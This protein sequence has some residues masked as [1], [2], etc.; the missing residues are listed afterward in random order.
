MSDPPTDLASAVVLDPGNERGYHRSPEMQQSFE[1][2]AARLLASDGWPDPHQAGARRLVA[3]LAL[4]GGGVKGIGLVGAVLVLDEAGYRFRAVAGSSAGAIAASLVTGLTKAGKPMTELRRYLQQLDFREFMP[5]GKVRAFFEHHGGKAGEF[6]TDAAV[7]A[8]QPGLYTGDYLKKWLTP[9]LH[10]D[11][12]VR[13]FADLKLTT[14]DDPELSLPPGHEYSLLVHTSDISRLRLVRLPWDYPLYGHRA[15]EEDP[16]EAVRASMSIPLFFEPVT[17][18]ALP[19][20]ITIPSPGGKPVTQRF[21]A[22]TVSWVDGGM[23]RN[24]PI[25]AFDRADGEPARWPTIGIKLS[26]L[27]TNH[28]PTEGA[29][30]AL[31]VAIHCLNTMTNEWDTYDIDET[32]AGRTVFVQNNGLKPTDFGLTPV[33]QDALFLNGVTAATEF[34]IEAAQ[35]GGVPRSAEASRALVRARAAS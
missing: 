12:G 32:T 27:D 20:A 33:Q 22:G 6:L 24:F 16:V 35:A 2:A 26:S 17:F 21:D 1:S 10:D 4:E 3:D 13:T 29:D 7:L 14:I 5:E 18:N 19:A 28:G 34:V 31:S 30:N 9:I 23:L 11:L 8:K 15:D 25:D